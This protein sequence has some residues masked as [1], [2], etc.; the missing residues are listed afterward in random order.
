MKS[1]RDAT[2]APAINKTDAIPSGSGLTCYRCGKKGQT[3]AK[4]RMSKNIICH[5]CGKPGH[6]Q[7]VCRSKGK[8]KPSQRGTGKRN[9]NPVRQLESDEETD[10]ESSDSD[11]HQ[12]CVTHSASSSPPITVQVEVDSCLVSMEVDT[13]VSHTLMSETL[14]SSSCGQGGACYPHLSDCQSNPL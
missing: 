2:P 7:K 1:E 3:V 11:V 13:G 14:S 9:T 10:S 12:I 6:I 4:C 5:N 8:G